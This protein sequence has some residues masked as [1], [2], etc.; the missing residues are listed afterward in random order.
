MVPPLLIQKAIIIFD[1]SDSAV[2]AHHTNKYTHTTTGIQ[3]SN[4]GKK[5]FCGG[6]SN[7]CDKWKTVLKKTTCFDV[8]TVTFRIQYMRKRDFSFMPTASFAMKVAYSETLSMLQVKQRSDG[9]IW[10]LQCPDSQHFTVNF[11]ILCANALTNFTNIQNLM[12]SDS[13]W[14]QN[15]LAVL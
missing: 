2:T 6:Y 13:H 3:S 9:L 10:L 5:H 4:E 15:A 8:F 14:S 11:P 7:Y 1:L 12:Q